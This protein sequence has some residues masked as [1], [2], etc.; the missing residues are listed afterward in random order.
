MTRPIACLSLV[1]ASL[2]LAPPALAQDRNATGRSRME[3]S[4]D[5]GYGFGSEGEFVEL[6]ADGRV[7]APFGLGVVARAGL[8]T[9]VFSNALALDLGAAYRLDL[10]DTPHAGLQLAIAVGPSVARGP[11]DGGEV[12]AFGGWSMLH[13]D[14]W[15][16]NF[17]VG[18]GATGHLMATTREGSD[19]V[20]GNPRSAPILTL[21]PMIRIGGEWG[22]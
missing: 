22:L 16:R 4:F 8:A 19:V 10:V 15:Y 14:F 13:L 6:A 5:H 20:D 18:L 12:W 17:F 7:Y 2:A 9:R 1:I 3:L 11:F 21:T